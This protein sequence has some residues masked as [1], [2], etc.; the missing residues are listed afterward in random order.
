L[1]EGLHYHRLS[2]KSENLYLFGQFVYWGISDI[3]KR[4]LSINAFLSVGVK[5][6][7]TVG[8]SFTS[9]CETEVKEGSG[10]RAPICIVA[11]RGE[12]GGRVPIPSTPQDM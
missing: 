9:N 1:G 2:E 6:G 3:C 7:K 10:K 5:V 8:N 4:T 12:P 11:L